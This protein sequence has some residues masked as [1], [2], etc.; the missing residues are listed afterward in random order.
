MREGTD[1]HVYYGWYR[2]QD[3]AQKL[4]GLAKRLRFV[5]EFG[6]QS[7]P[8]YESSIRFMAKELG[9]IDWGL[10]EARHSLQRKVMD[11]WL[12]LGSF[13][14]LEQLIEA[15]Q[16]HQ[17]AVNRAYV[18]RLRF[19]KYRPVGGV[20]AFSFHDP[21]PAVQWSVVDYWRVPKRSYYPLKSAF[22]PQYVFTL[23]TARK[24]AVGE[25]IA[26]PIYVVNDSP[27]AYDEVGISAEIL[28]GKGERTTHAEFTCALP[29]DSEAELVRLLHFRFKEAGER[30][31]RLRLEYGREVFENEYP[32]AIAPV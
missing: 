13:E 24:F 22:H 15:S 12:D 26:V 28:S 10:L 5:T 32:L 19:H 17:I 16:E 30:K 4:E 20:L 6:A 2:R 9:Q 31:L 1:S 14:E 11:K 27:Q 18:D 3:P 29:A 7:F 23:L 8:N 25:E 21:N